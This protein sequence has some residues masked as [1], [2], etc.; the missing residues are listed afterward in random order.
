MAEISKAEAHPPAEAGPVSRP[1]FFAN[2]EA[3]SFAIALDRSGKLHFNGGELYGDH[4]VVLLGRD[5]ADQ[6]LAELAADGVSYVVSQT[7][8]MDVSAMLETLNKELG[9]KQILLEGGAG[10]N[11]SLLAAG[12]VDELSFV[13]A[14]ALEARKNS[15]RVVEY[16]EE[17]LAGKVELSLISCEPLEH[18]ALH[19]RYKVT[20]PG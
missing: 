16:G 10:V 3:K 1:V 5:V 20:Q 11:G 9:I 13:L 12:L 14:P 15:D 18:G 19:L 4:V 2:R 8:E 7:E 6:H 17:G